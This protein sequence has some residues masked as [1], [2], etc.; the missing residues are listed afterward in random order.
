MLLLLLLTVT[1]QT[2]IKEVRAHCYCASYGQGE[3]VGISDGRIAN[4]SF[5]ASSYYFNYPPWKAR[6]NS[7]DSNAWYGKP[8]DL[9]SW[10]QVRSGRVE[11]NRYL[12]NK[13]RNSYSLEGAAKEQQQQQQHLFK[14][15][16]NYSGADVVVY[17][18]S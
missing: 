10:I 4:S 14:H 6:L 1:P 18:R 2:T 11:W 15:D 12:S 9:E 7:S 13:Y 8:W 5:T 3:P 16:K 17:L